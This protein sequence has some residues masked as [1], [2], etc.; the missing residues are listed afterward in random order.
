MPRFSGTSLLHFATL[1]PKLQTILEEAI[2]ILDFAIICG[3]RGEIDQ[4]KA[5]LGGKSKL[6]WPNSRHNSWP[7]EAVDIVPFPVDWTNIPAFKRLADIVIGTAK[8]HGVN[9]RWGGDWDRDGVTE[10]NEND[11]VHFELAR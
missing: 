2:T 8:T 7:S 11:L 4:A 6:K 10:K 3:H 1:H 9:L 5:Y